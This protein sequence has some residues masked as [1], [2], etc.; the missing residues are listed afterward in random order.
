MELDFSFSYKSTGKNVCHKRL[1]LKLS[2]QKLSIQWT[3]QTVK[4]N[5]A[6]EFKQTIDFSKRKNPQDYFSDTIYI[7]KEDIKCV[8]FRWI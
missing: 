8:I 7:N 2:K 5:Y 6:N 3:C 1:E 4:Q